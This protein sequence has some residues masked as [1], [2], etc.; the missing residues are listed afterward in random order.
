[1]A[2]AI[3]DI[4]M[5]RVLGERDGLIKRAIASLATRLGVDTEEIETITADL[6]ESETTVEQRVI[7]D[8]KNKFRTRL[9]PVMSMSQNEANHKDFE[10][11]MFE[12]E[13]TRLCLI[14]TNFP[15][16]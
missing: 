8:I 10:I 16:I 9:Q 11:N 1:M 6:K 12:N 3:H 13:N 4:E 15:K 14:L 5:Q 2:D 7:H